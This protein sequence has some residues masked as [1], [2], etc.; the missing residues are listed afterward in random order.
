[1]SGK[2]GRRK[3]SGYSCQLH[4]STFEIEV[5]LRHQ[6]GRIS[7]AIGPCFGDFLGSRC[8]LKPCERIRLTRESLETKKSSRL[9][10]EP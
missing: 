9:K 6:R 3:D 8:T 7:V 1:M 4:F 5:P 10:T 2:A